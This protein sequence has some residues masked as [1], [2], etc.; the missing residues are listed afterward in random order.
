MSIL[1]QYMSRVFLGL[2]VLMALAGCATD[3]GLSS[4]W[5]PTDE[6]GRVVGT[7][8]EAVD[9][10]VA[11]NAVEGVLHSLMQAPNYRSGMRIVVEPVANDTRFELPEAEFNH[12]IRGQLKS[13]VPNRCQIVATEGEQKV[14]FYLMGKLQRIMPD[15]PRGYE[16]LFYSYQLV[17]AANNEIFWEGSCEVR[18]HLASGVSEPLALVET[19]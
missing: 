16:I 17:D 14:T 1:K 9:L 8:F 12:A 19:R 15:E 7:G 10:M 18:T 3:G 13:T 11:C 5:I 2:G 4:R 6:Q